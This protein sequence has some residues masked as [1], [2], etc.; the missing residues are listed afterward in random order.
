VLDAA[1][2]LAADKAIADVQAA[3]DRLQKAIDGRWSILV[4][5]TGSESAASAQDND[6][7]ASRRLLADLQAR[8]PDLD[9]DHVAGFLE[10][11]GAA[12]MVQASVAGANRATP[13]TF[14]A[15]VVDTTVDQ[16]TTPGLWPTWLWTA[17]GVG[18]LVVLA[19]IAAPMV[20]PMLFA[21]R[22]VS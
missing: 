14:K 12:A 15:E 10:L 4:S 21:R 19:V 1:N 16:V 2:A 22:A 6:L 13:E 3:V 18:A 5:L 8:R 20:L 11:A 17:I 9:N 7:A